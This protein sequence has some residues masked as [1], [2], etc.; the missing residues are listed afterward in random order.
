MEWRLVCRSSKK[1][2]K[3]IQKS[4]QR[5]CLQRDAQS[6]E[7]SDHCSTNLVL[8]NLPG[9]G[10][11]FSSGRTLVRNYQPV[12]RHEKLTR[13]PVSLSDGISYPT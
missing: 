2:K 3:K 4:K 5:L 6:N 1:K 11:F 12:S 10:D 13:I 9:C 7:T 8:D